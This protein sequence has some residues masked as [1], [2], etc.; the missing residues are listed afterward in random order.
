MR[1]LEEM[2]LR[3]NKKNMGISRNMIYMEEF[4]ILI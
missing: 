3:T 4:L 2:I 1:I